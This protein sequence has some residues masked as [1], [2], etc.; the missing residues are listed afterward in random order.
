MVVI[1]TGAWSRICNVCGD[2]D[3]GSTCSRALHICSEVR[4]TALYAALQGELTARDHCW[5]DR[6]NSAGEISII[7]LGIAFR[8][9]FW[10]MQK[11]EDFIHQHDGNIS[12]WSCLL[13]AVREECWS[14]NW[15]PAQTWRYSTSHTV[16]THL[17]RTRC[18][19][20]GAL[21]EDFAITEMAPTRVFSWL[22]API[23]LFTFKTLLRHNA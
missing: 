22:K 7:L 8:F 14:C 17:G 16:V 21:Y 15:F 11:W 6:Y 3:H 4:T 12:C 5:L 9:A 18:L 2:H 10:G 19:H 13:A 23:S 20:I 1:G